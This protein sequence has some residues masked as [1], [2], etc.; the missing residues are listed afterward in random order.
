[1]KHH[2]CVDKITAKEIAE[3]A[4]INEAI[5]CRTING[6]KTSTNTLILIC[7]ALHLQYKIC[8]NI[9]DLSPCPLRMSNP[10]QQWDAFTLKVHYEKQLVKKNN[11]SANIVQARY[12]K[13]FKSRT[14]I[15]R[16]LYVKLLAIQR[17]KQLRTLYS[18][19]F[20]FLANELSSKY[21]I[22]YLKNVAL[23]K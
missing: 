6:E 10:N 21:T 18:Y 11:Y 14:R 2:K 5:V 4:G 1:M 17:S 13:L 20:A 22:L 3:H 16:F 19:F 15:I 9:I 7:F 12:K 8:R 23:Y